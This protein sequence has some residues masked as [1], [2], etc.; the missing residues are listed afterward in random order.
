MLRDK[1]GRLLQGHYALTQAI[2]T[3]TTPVAIPTGRNKKV[4]G[5]MKDEAGGEFTTE[6]V[7]LRPKLYA[8]TTEDT[9]VKNCKAVRKPVIEKW[10]NFDHYKD[11]LFNKT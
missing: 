6:F 4:P 9:C 10:L 8:F 11:C 2:T 1:N 5:M 7:G 3:L